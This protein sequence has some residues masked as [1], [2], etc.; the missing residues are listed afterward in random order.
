MKKTFSKEYF[1]LVA[2]LLPLLQSCEQAVELGTLPYEEKLVVQAVLDPEES[3]PQFYFTRTFSLNE[4][5]TPEKAAIRNVVGRI[6]SEGIS[7]PLGY[8]GAL[9]RGTTPTGFATYEAPGL[10]IRPGKTYTLV[11]SWNGHSL[12]VTTRVPDSATVDTTYLRKDS[13]LVGATYFVTTELK[14]Q[15]N[16]VYT[17]DYEFP[18]IVFPIYGDF[19]TALIKPSTAGEAVNL[20]VFLGS[21]YYSKWKDSLY[22]K[23]ISFDEPFYEYYGSRRN[24]RPTSLGY[25]FLGGSPGSVFWNVEGDGLGMFIGRTVTKKKVFVP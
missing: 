20:N 24:S 11:A 21:S 7:Y 13:S 12:E 3:V 19:R 8:A 17:A 4:I 14:S 25:S 10:V 2:W 18:G 9:V 23:V 15:N 6:E 5:F 1:F 16:T 22:S